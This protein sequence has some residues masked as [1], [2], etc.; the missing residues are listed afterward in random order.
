MQAQTATTLDAPTRRD[1][2]A[3]GAWPSNVQI[4]ATTALDPVPPMY[5]RHGTMRPSAPLAHPDLIG[6]E[7]IADEAAR[8]SLGPEEPTPPRGVRAAPLVPVVQGPEEG[9]A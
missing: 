6:S 4:D 9:R 2:I 1:V 3:M 7:D 8:P 5:A